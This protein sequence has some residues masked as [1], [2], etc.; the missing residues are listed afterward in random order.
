MNAYVP[1]LYMPLPFRTLLHEILVVVVPDDDGVVVESGLEYETIVVGQYDLVVHVARGRVS[2][3]ALT[4]EL[5]ED[6]GSNRGT[7]DVRVAAPKPG[8]QR[9]DLAMYS[10]QEMLDHNFDAHTREG[11]A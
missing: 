11:S 3:E 7:L 8:H 9:L 1:G 10:F 2:Q 5:V 4:L 6:L